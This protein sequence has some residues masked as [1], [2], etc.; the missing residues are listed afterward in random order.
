MGTAIL[1]DELY[2]AG[3]NLISSL[4]KQGVDI[5]TAFLTKISEEDYAWALVVAMEG[6]NANGSRQYYQQILQTIQDND[7]SLSLPDVRV[8]DKDDSIVQALQKMVHT[9]KDINKINFFGNY[10]NG[11][12]FPDS[13]IYRVS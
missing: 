2:E 8:L 1:V 12:R 3:K 7:I 9:G 4:D 13:I 10:I 6:V 5:S 11:Q